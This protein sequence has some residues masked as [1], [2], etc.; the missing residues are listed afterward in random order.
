MYMELNGKHH[1]PHFHAK[2]N[3]FEAIYDF[4]GNLLGGNM[5][6]KQKKLVEAWVMLHKDE[7]NAVWTAWNESGE[8]IKIEGLK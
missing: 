6:Y 3:E 4:D 1:I 5:P 8:V 2:Y 7:L